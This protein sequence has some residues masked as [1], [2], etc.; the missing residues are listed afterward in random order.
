MHLHTSP[1]ECTVLPLVVQ[2]ILI[3]SIILDTPLF[4]V[5]THSSPTL[6]PYEA[7]FA[8]LVSS[9]V[10]PFIS[11][12][13]FQ[14][15]HCSTFTNWYVLLYLPISSLIC[16]LSQQICVDSQM[17]MTSSLWVCISPTEGFSPFDEGGDW[18]WDGDECGGMG[19][20]PIS[21]VGESLDG[22]SDTG[23]HDDPVSQNRSLLHPRRSLSGSW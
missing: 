18:G 11:S 1:Y 23:A 3:H 6:A 13:V 19:G 15:C 4:T 10:P 9:L 21:G 12:H 17:A 7:L 20:D 8:I 16:L 2:D 5:L 22:L 14:C